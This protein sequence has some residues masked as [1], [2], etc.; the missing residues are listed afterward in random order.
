MRQ[1][2]S[3]DAQFLAI[4]SPRT[5]GHVSGLAVLDPS[6]A[7]GGRL[8][9]ADVCRLVAERLPLLPPLRWRLVP[10]P[11]GLDHPSWVEDP[12]FDL[13]F[14]VRE[15][16]LPPDAGERKLAEQVARIV[17]RP[18]D[19]SRPLWEMYVIHGLPD[20]RVAL[21]T[22]IHHAVVDGVSGAEIFS[23]L[24]DIAPEGRDPVPADDHELAERVPGDLELLARA[25]AG[26]PL[27][28]LR[29]LRAAPRTLPYLQALPGVRDVPGLGT[30]SRLAQRVVPGGPDRDVLE[31]TTQ[32]APRTPFNGPISAHRR[33]AFTEL[34]LDVVKAIKDEHGCTVNDVV[35][36]LCAGAV[37]RWLIARGALPADPLIAMVPMSVR[38][39]EQ[40]GTF[41][42][43]VSMM[44]VPIAT[45]EPDPRR[46]LERIHEVLRT[47]KERHR[48]LPA[49]LLTD[50]TRFIPPAVAALAAR[51]ALS[52]LADRRPP[53]NLIISNVPGPQFPLYCAGA[54][55]EAHYPVSAIADGVG[56]NMT[57][58]SYLGRLDFGIVADRE[59]IDDA[60]ALTHG[61]RE[62]L[63]ALEALRPRFAK[64]P[65]PRR[66]GGPQR[67]R[68]AS[69]RGSPRADPS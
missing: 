26:L 28:P 40:F 1:L 59:Q 16:A 36:A 57:V 21:L 43:R 45:D 10:V 47:A 9:L 30:V 52:V 27:Q 62:E 13:E 68:R 38:T 33:F 69:R 37:R 53:V 4:E 31:F 50:A 35:V 11:L 17:S 29:A 49:N 14:H 3:L 65:A 6:T 18:L 46:R 32:P 20:G 22:K 67:P 8:A 41:G 63:A 51:T 39:S 64:A 2:S 25:I 12:D 66:N 19:R 48:A 54:R 58:M 5:V 42:N 61:L 15:L 7:P 24:L 23:A 34:P 55:L 56:L 60:W 44:V